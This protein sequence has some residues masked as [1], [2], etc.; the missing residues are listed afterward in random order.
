MCPH[1]H[2]VLYYSHQ[3]WC[4]FDVYSFLFLELWR[5]LWHT[6]CLLVHA[7][8]PCVEGWNRKCLS[9]LPVAHFHFFSPRL[10]I[11][12]RI[13][14]LLSRSMFFERQ[15]LCVWLDGDVPSCHQFPNPVLHYLFHLF[16]TIW[17]RRGGENIKIKTRSMRSYPE[18]N[19]W[20]HVNV[21]KHVAC[22]A[23]SPM[24][25]LLI[26]KMCKFTWCGCV[27]LWHQALS[28]LEC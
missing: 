3:L 1:R 25:G 18:S 21:M 13:R 28:M 5:L 20:V 15:G 10:G 6:L 4:E 8:V 7:K 12:V 26:K 24:T 22:V 2:C 11:I 14:L 19:P 27:F 16:S 17:K 23:T 9:L